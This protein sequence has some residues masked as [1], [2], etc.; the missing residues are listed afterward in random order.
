MR[1]QILEHGKKT[2]ECQFIL[3]HKEPER[4]GG[5]DR[6]HIYLITNYMDVQAS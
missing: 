1:T 6:D 5:C 4:R 2:E 3:C